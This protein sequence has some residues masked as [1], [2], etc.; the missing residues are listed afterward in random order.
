MEVSVSLFWDVRRFIGALK[1][2]RHV[3]QSLGFNLS[4]TGY[5]AVTLLLKLSKKL[6]KNKV[7]SCDRPIDLSWLLTVLLQTLGVQ[8]VLVEPKTHFYHSVGGPRALV[9]SR[10]AKRC[11]IP[12]HEMLPDVELIQGN[13]EEVDIEGRKVWLYEGQPITYD[14]LV[15]ATGKI[16]ARPFRFIGLRSSSSDDRSEMM[17]S[18]NA[19]H[20]EVFSAPQLLEQLKKQ[21]KRLKAASLVVVVGGTILGVES[22]A[23]I[24]AKFPNKKVV[25]YHAR[26]RLLNDYH[27]VSEVDS[28]T[29]LRKLREQGIEVHLN[30]RFTEED[31]SE[32]AGTSF[33]LD[34]CGGAPRSDFMPE[35][36]L[37]KEGYLKVDANLNVRGS[38]RVFAMG[39]SI[40]GTNGSKKIALLGHV[41][42]VLSNVLRVLREEPKLKK[43]SNKLGPFENAFIVTLGPNDSLTCGV[44]AKLGKFSGSAKQGDYWIAKF[45]KD[46]GVKPE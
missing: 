15:V 44:M 8:L 14:I 42:V 16:Y 37:T 6:Q 38:K 13:V 32:L 5:S 4:P 40:T 28:A 3:L 20:P 24:K 35:N 17:Q 9:D 36:S 31:K 23:E 1:F 25:L 29:V 2:R 19:F 45:L 30:T 10:Y 7:S 46:F 34:C 43:L 33:I 26:S 21:R 22:S 27:E 41:P 12:Y 11:F 18:Q 39:D